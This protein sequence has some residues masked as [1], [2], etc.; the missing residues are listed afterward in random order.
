MVL[1]ATNGAVSITLPA[2]GAAAG[3]WIDFAVES[4]MTD[5]CIPTIATAT[6]DTLVMINGIDA[7]SVTFGTGHRIGAYCRMW[8][9]GSFWHYQNMGP[10]TITVNDSD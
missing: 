6:A 10:T 8:S 2:N 3:A 7:D 9:D 5:S 1:I 4:S